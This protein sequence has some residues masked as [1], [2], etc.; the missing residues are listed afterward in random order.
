[1]GYIYYLSLI[2][3]FLS[4]INNIKSVLKNSHSPHEKS[5]TGEI[6]ER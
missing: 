1:M 2:F 4:G 6:T 3:N 5:D